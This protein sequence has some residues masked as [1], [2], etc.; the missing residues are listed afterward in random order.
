MAYFKV[1]YAHNGVKYIYIYLKPPITAATNVSNII[2][3][4]NEKNKSR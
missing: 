1:K 2:K 3:F 4:L